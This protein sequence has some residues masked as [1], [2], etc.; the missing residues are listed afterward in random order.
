MSKYN[1]EDIV[2]FIN[3]QMDETEAAAFGLEMNNN[4]TLAEEVAAQLQLS[5]VVQIASIK[6]RLDAIHLEYETVEKKAVAIPGSNNVRKLFGWL[7]AAAA[8]AGL[9]IVIFLFKSGG[10]S[11]NQQIFAANFKDDAGAPSLMGDKATPFDDAMI[12][13][14]S[15][16]YKAAEGK[17]GKLLFDKPQ[18]DTLKYY[19][20]LC[21]VRLKNE[22][23]ALQLLTSISQPADS[24]LG[25]K[26][27]WYSALI[28]VHEDK[29]GEAKKLLTEL[30]NS[31]SEY[32]DKAGELLS[33]LK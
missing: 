1:T 9:A 24:N 32:A 27:K 31:G 14:K 2:R 13:Y 29:T 8:I 15:G 4:T 11:N 6:Q 21:Q 3:G 33:Q 7:A 18:N 28:L 17:F 20:A 12:Y 16:D 22:D 5:R 23:S 19:D 26:A 25:V 30:K 10:N